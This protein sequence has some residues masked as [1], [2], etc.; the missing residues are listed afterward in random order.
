MRRNDE[1]GHQQK[2][3]QHVVGLEVGW[4][5]TESDVGEIK[6]IL[7]GLQGIATNKLAILLTIAKQMAEVYIEESK[8][9]RQLTGDQAYDRLS[10]EAIGHHNGL[11]I[12][13]KR[14]YVNKTTKLRQT[15]RVKKG[16]R[17]RYEDKA[18]AEWAKASM[19]PAV[20]KTEEHLADLRELAE[21]WVK[22]R[23]GVNTAMKRI[24]KKMEDM[25]SAK[26]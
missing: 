13:W 23:K 8:T 7:S 1:T 11:R 15:A 9:Q 22:L 21:Q 26:A 5:P 6:D 10:V 17:Y 19:L 4:V 25:R 18:L 24:I 20:L 16:K 12:G 2:T 3:P 14:A